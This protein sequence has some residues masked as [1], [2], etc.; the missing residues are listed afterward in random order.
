MS[1]WRFLIQ[2]LRFYA[3]SHAGAF[4]GATIASAI[5]IGALIVG[6][7]VRG[8][9]FE[10]AMSRLGRIDTI[11]TG[12]DRLFRDAL[13]NEMKGETFAEVV[14][15]IQL[16]AVASASGGSTRA[17]QTQIV[18]ITSDFWNLGLNP[19]PNVHPKPDEATL[20]Q[21]LARQL[22]VKEGDPFILRIQKPSRISPDAPLAPDENTSLALRLKV[23]HIVGD[24]S[25]GRFSLQ[26]SQLPALNAF[27]DLE[28]LQSELDIPGKANLLLLA[29]ESNSN[30][31]ATDGSS[32]Q[33][34]LKQ[35]W[36]L[37]D[38]Q[39]SWVDL[40][41]NNGRGF[42]L[43]TERVFM[44][45]TSAE[46]AVSG[47]ANS[48]G[49]LTYFV[50]AIKKGDQLTP[51]S[52]VTAAEAPFVPEDLK[53][54]EIILNQWLAEDLDAKPGDSVEMTYYIVGLGRELNEATSAFTV[55]QIVPMQ[56]PYNDP[57]FMPDFPGL[58]DADN[59][60]D[61]DTGFPID[62]DLIRDH[63]NEYWETHK[64]TP[65]AF[66]SLS[67]GKEI[68][69]NRF[70][71][72]TA[73]RYPEVATPDQKAQLESAILEHLQ[74]SK[75]GIMS[76]PVKSQAWNSVVESQDFGG[77]FIGFSFFLI[78]AAL[79]LMNL[80]F[81]F[82]IEQ[83]TREAGILM[84]V[85]MTPKR[86]KQFLLREGMLISLLG[87]VAGVGLAILYAKGMLHG[88]ST[89]WS[90]AVGTSSLH[91]HFNP[92]TVFGGMIGSIAL[93]GMTLWWGLRK[94]IQKPAHVLLTE[95]QVEGQTIDNTSRG[96][97]RRLMAGIA[98]G[99]GALGIA[100]LGKF[101]DPAQA[102]GA[103]FGAGSLLLM[104][105][106]MLA[107]A[108]LRGVT[109][110][111]TTNPPSLLQWGIRNASR[112]RKRSLATISMLAFGSFLVIAVGANKLDALRDADKRSSGTGGFAFWGESTAPV[113]KNLNTEEGAESYG[114]FRDELEGV[115]IVP[116][117]RRNGEEASCLNLNR[118]QR[119]RLLGVN[120]DSLASRKA[121]TFA[122]TWNEVPEGSSAWNL[123]SE[124]E[125]D[126]TIPG[127]ADYNSIMWAMGK[128]VGDV[129]IFQNTQGESFRVRLVA[130][131]ANSILQGNVIIAE[132]AFLKH[133]PNEPGYKTFLLDVPSEKKEDLASALTRAL[134]D[135]G[136]TLFDAVERMQAFNA[137]QNTYLSTFQLLGGLGMI[138]GSFGLGVVVLRNL[139]D[140]RTEL[141]LLAA[142][143]FTRKRIRS[144]VLLEHIGLLFY[145]L[146]T[147]VISA[148]IAVIP[149]LQSPGANIPYT[150]LTWTLLAIFGT[151]FIW[152]CIATQAALKGQ[153]LDSLRNQ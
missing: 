85:G 120:P 27:V 50:N 86:L 49:L 135:D 34:S 131:V 29:P 39:L 100:A 76:I 144:L 16:P 68:W 11:I 25:M 12:N 2:S 36:T 66:I 42:E 78:A 9:L 84:A 32:A 152:T 47:G 65:K 43:R 147:G 107:S 101:G 54:N 117:K 13:A 18:G 99:L 114:L 51:Y 31:A 150:S 103:F 128:S 132:S 10:M 55:R 57:Y 79:I 5:L 71:S 69:Q 38:S 122:K 125:P 40:N 83:R 41:Q 126:G 21:A 14:P 52:M 59:C 19:T 20:S 153:L 67:K 87:H 111:S 75:L 35:H 130:G 124:I 80:L 62:L 56:A 82:V 6:D 58:K 81:Q 95:N 37:E 74:P 30:Q 106:L 108:Y 48:S 97:T 33:E 3:R 127:I 8:S 45:D 4:L 24:A 145:G 129:L 137:V 123:L 151:G 113:V 23:A 105:G 61:W 98:C 93:T 70:G 102:T 139:L 143:G 44:D 138:L 96:A 104:S 53:D 63:D 89:I 72:L 64:G 1:A 133:F 119:P 118:A 90:D 7:S 60:R 15:A 140:R 146:L 28:Y 92:P 134:E 26:A 88:L 46:T 17:N 115:S 136:L 94:Q 22:K 91:F 109:N 141:G 121:F 77:L 142:I 73:V 116:F 110:H 149:S 148:W 112:R